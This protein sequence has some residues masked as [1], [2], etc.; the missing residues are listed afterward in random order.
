MKCGCSANAISQ[1]KPCC[2]IHFGSTPD[3]FIPVE[4]PDLTNRTASCAYCGTEVPSDI[5]LAFF[6]HRPTYKTDSFYDGCFN[7]D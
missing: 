4:P 5:K 7:W 3:A 2:S 1:G 6:Q